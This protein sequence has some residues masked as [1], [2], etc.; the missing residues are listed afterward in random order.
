MNLKRRTITVT[1]FKTIFQLITEANVHFIHL[2]I[3]ELRNNKKGTC[4]RKYINE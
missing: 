2:L 3:Y 4:V 1:N